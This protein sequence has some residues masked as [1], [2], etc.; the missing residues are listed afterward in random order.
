MARMIINKA[1]S[2]S[3][4]DKMDTLTLNNLNPSHIDET[5][6]FNKAA[7]WLITVLSE[8]NIP[9]TVKNLGAGVKRIYT[10]VSFCPLCKRK[11]PCST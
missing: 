3:M 2:D 4:R 11:L 10:D 8:R 1:W 5:I 9:F 7:Q 6:R